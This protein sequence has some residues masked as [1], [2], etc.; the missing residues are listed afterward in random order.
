MPPW[1]ADAPGGTHIGDNVLTPVETTRLVAWVNAGAPSGNG[2]DPLAQ[3]PSVIAE[4][5]PGK[6]D[7]I[8]ECPPQSI[9]PTGALSYR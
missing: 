1:G 9:P 2:A 7:L 5:P 8:V 6:P 3:A 4:C